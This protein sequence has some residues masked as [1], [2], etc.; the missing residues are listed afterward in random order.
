MRPTNEL[1]QSLLEAYS[2]FNQALFDAKL[3]EVIFTVQRKKGVLGYFAPDRWSS[4]EG[5]HCHEI[6]INPAHLGQSRIIDIFQTLVHE[7]VH[8]WQYCFGTPGRRSYHNKEWAY[9]MIKI[10][11]HP[12]S[13][14]LPGGDIVGEQMSDYPIDDGLFLKACEVL[15]AAQSFNIPWIDRLSSP[16]MP[17]HE[18][19]SNTS[20]E[21]LTAHH[22]ANEITHNVNSR[23][24]DVTIT[25]LM[26]MTYSE[27]LPEETFI[28]SPQKKRLKNTYQC[29][30]CH[31][32]VWGKPN[33]H[34]ICGD[35]SVAFDF[36]VR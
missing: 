11:L 14:G 9:K 36:L 19:S 27:L 12:T 7:M 22:A 23:D 34:I 17:I 15:L 16:K 31:N 4:V 26:Q 25:E 35:C 24:D 32:R 8:C 10:G 30:Q 6:A 13:T 33:M 21:I 29:P 3:P 28:A 18:N 1:Y 2:H 20:V 5:K